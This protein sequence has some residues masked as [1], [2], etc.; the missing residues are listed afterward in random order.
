VFENSIVYSHFYEKSFIIGI[1]SIVSFVCPQFLKAVPAYPFPVKVIQPDGTEIAIKLN[2]DEF[3]HYQTTL[4]GYLITRDKD[5]FFKYGK[6][7]KKGII[8]PSKYRVNNIEKR[9]KEEIIL[10]NSFLNL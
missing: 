5:G 2:G 9:T 1:L 3:F 7:S 8:T 10:S 6:L 4:D